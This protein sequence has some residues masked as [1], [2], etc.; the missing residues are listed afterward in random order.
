MKHR[1]T[2]PI[3]QRF[4]RS[5]TALAAIGLCTFSLGKGRAAEPPVETPVTITAGTVFNLAPVFDDQGN[6]VFPWLHEVR[7]L[8]Q[9]SSLGNCVV[10]FH[11]SI[12]GG[13]ACEG[14]HAFCLSGTMTI[15]T[16]AGDKLLANVVGWADPDPKDPKPNPSM[17]L[18][19]YD[20][21]ITGGTG[22]LAGAGGQ[23]IVTGAFMFSDTD[24]TDD[25]DHSD[26]VFCNSYAGVATWRFDGV[27]QSPAGPRLMIQAAPNKTVTVSWPASEQGWQL[28][29]KPGLDHPSWNDVTAATE[30]LEG[31]KRAALPAS[32][33]NRF[34][35]LR[36]P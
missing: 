24:D 3:P 30:E 11:V 19:H 6:P 5:V 33:G 4:T 35:R 18:L 2:I 22:T 34:Y 10:G 7:G 20:A 12:N 32:E 21:T 16:L 15:T 27:V 9:V 25:P 14:N 1:F 31:R 17:Y 23:G 36:K 13:N 26:N 29:E 28:Q 8:V